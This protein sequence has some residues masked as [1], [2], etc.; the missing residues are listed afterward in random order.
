MTSDASAPAQSSVE[1]T[2]TLDRGETPSP[3]SDHSFEQVVNFRDFGGHAAGDGRR[4]RTGAL[5]RSANLASASPAD[6][7]RLR[8]LAVQV[9]LDLRRP[10]ERQAQP[11]RW[12]EDATPRV[13]VS[14]HGADHNLPPHLRFLTETEDLTAAASRDYM[15]SAYRRI[16]FEPAHIAMFRDAF[17]ALAEGEAPLLVHC[18][19]GKD[20]TGV[21]CA[22]VLTALDVDYATL[23][24]D[25]LETNNS[26]H[27][28][29]VLERFVK[30]MGVRLGRS[31]GADE[32]MPMITVD[33]AYLEAAWS[34]ITNRHGSIEAYMADSLGLTEAM[35]ARLHDTLLEGDA[36]S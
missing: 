18:A 36:K 14:D 31:V 1:D 3:A 8:A 11:S 9:A 25:Y 4:V 20:R 2:P 27:L 5:Y 13:I 34:E 30:H 21:F 7:D 16:P 35:R 28:S 32:L 23:E 19:A 6:Q 29:T 15:I 10:S 22:L 17:H 24:V 12:P 26:P 33:A